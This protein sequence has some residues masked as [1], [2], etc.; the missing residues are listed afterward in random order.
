MEER[1]REREREKA[2]QL[3]GHHWKYQGANFICFFL[4]YS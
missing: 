4:K 2:T 1:K 3:M